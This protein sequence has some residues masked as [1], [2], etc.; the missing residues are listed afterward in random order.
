VGRGDEDVDGAI[1]EAAGAVDDNHG[2]IV[3]VGNSL[4]GLLAF[5]E[6]EHAHGLAREDGGFHGVGQFIDIE[7]SDALDARDLIEIEI[8]GDDFGVALAGEFDELEIDSGDRRKIVLEN[9][10]IEP[11]HFLHALK[12]FESATAALALEGVG[13]VGDELELVEDEARNAE[14]AVEEMCFANVGDAAVDERAGVE[15]LGRMTGGRGEFDG[16]GK[17]KFAERRSFGGT[18]NETE[19]RETEERGELEER[20]GRLRFGCTGDDHRNQE[21][22]EQTEDSTDRSPHKPADLRTAQS[23]FSK[24]DHQGHE[25][26]DTGGG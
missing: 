16:L 23:Q 2:A 24:K 25:K 18:D 5:A 7:N 3:E 19:I 14:G 21:G 13:R 8:I 26:A 1:D 22:G 11:G 17:R 12:N 9:A 20:L 4:G 6:D 15:Q 10:E